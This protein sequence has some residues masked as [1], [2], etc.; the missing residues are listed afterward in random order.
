MV[1]DPAKCKKLLLQTF[2]YVSPLAWTIETKFGRVYIPKGFLSDG[3]SC[4][5]DL[6]Y[7]AFFTHDLL[8]IL[9]SIEG[10]IVPKWKCDLIYSMLLTRNK[11]YIRAFVRLS[12]LLLFGQ[13]AWYKYRELDKSDPDHWRDHILPQADRWNI[14]GFML[15]DITLRE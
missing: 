12:G 3:A 7:E 14:P 6:C 2:Y 1:C 9:P 13:P 10:K 4:V 8:Y 5:P 11:R 15:K